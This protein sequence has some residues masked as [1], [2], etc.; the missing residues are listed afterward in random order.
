[1]ATARLHHTKTGE[2]KVVA[3]DRALKA[4]S[5]PVATAKRVLWPVPAAFPLHRAVP[6][7]AM[8]KGAATTTARETPTPSPRLAMHQSEEV[9]DALNRR[10]DSILSIR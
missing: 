2:E 6:A 5:S 10:P 3:A 4:E 8:D 1:M 9:S 7:T